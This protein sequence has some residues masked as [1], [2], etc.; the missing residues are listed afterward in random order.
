M[1]DTRVSDRS[2]YVVKSNDLIKYSRF[3]FTLEEQRV[4]LFAISKIKPTDT[5]DTYYEF[6]I[7]DICH[8]CGLDD[9]A[10]FYYKR[11][12]DA[13]QTLRD[14]SWYIKM[15]NQDEV[16]VSWLGKIRLSPGSGTVKIRFDE[17]LQPYL[18]ELKSR[19]TQ[20]RLETVLSFKSKYAIRLYELLRSYNL[21]RTINNGGEKDIDF[22]VEDLKQRLDAETYNLYADFK[23]KVLLKAIDDINK[24]S[25]DMTVSMEEIHQGRKVI[26]INFIVSYPKGKQ[27]LSARQ[28]RRDELNKH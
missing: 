17:D 1:K 21:D 28:S 13:L 3:S 8:A 16:T 23:R 7:T 9:D 24:Y 20:Y 25:D 14:K 19:Y 22:E 10:G 11:L 15:P 26:K 6:N 12:K 4:L 27:I 2:Q 5:V 18:F